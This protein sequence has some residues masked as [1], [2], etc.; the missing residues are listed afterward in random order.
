MAR[1]IPRWLPNSISL[2]RVLLV[3]IWVLF[4]EAANAV[5]T[6]DGDATVHR[7]GAAS[8]LLAI[9]ASDI[10][11]GWLARRF[12]LQSRL[13]AA[14]DA[15][16]D[17]L[18]QVVLFAY[19]ALRTG[20]AFAPVPLWFLGIL[21]GRDGLLLF[22]FF[23]LRRRC[24]AVETEHC[25]HGRI[26]SLLLFVLLV[27]VSAGIAA[28]LLMPLLAISAAVAVTSTMLYFRRGIGQFRSAR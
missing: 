10:L 9:G 8:V 13:G 18:T 7:A 22:G 14:L 17:K 5:A 11:D 27:L 28:E 20:P 23:V 21:I 25:L 15:I 1:A 2:L 3:P 6:R 24:G 19:L 16:A 12:G 4:A 26:S